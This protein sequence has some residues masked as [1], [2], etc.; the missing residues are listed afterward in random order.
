MY[1][2]RIFLYRT[3]SLC[4][5]SFEMNRSNSIFGIFYLVTWNEIPPVSSFIKNELA[6]SSRH[7]FCE[8]ITLDNTQFVSCMFKMQSDFSENML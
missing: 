7:S 3:I 6:S 2:E 5:H 4:V 1:C 8:I